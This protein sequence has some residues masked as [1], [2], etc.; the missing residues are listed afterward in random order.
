MFFCGIDLGTRSSAICIIN[1]NK[2]VIRQWAGSN[3]EL[4][5]E[6]RAFGQ[7][8]TCVVEAS[9][10][11]ESLCLKVE[12]LG[13]NIEI[14]DSRHTRALLHGKKKTDKI[15][16]RTLA[17]L[18][19]IGWYKPVYRKDGKSREQRTV[20]RSRAEIVNTATRTKNSIRGLLKALGIVL[21]VGGS[22]EEFAF[23]VKE[24]VEPLS[25]EIQTAMGSL[26]TVWQLA[27]AEQ[28]KAYRRLKKMAE[29][30]TV[31]RRLMTVPGVGPATAIGF[32]STI[33][34]HERFKSPQQLVSYLGLAPKVHQS[35]DIHYHGRIT[36][37]GDRLLRWLLV[38]SA[39][40]IL[41]RVKKPFPLKDWGLKMAEKK[42]NAKAIVAVA[43]KLAILLFT[44]WRKETDFIVTA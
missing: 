31:A 5:E 19:G 24:A 41:S 27:H 37:Q 7:K 39:S 36:K 16:A 11:A 35:G 18:A 8:M 14:V 34:S 42:G 38:E 43:R 3:S 26:L 2:E 44:I 15:D 28:K 22:G 20:L 29:N 30:D 12:A 4:I 1:K 23:K 21:P 13:H 33:A 6:L 40:C 32:A 10:L 17:E 25:A 9:P